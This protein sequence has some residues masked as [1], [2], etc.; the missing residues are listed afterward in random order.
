MDQN[1]VLK[2]IEK[3]VRDVLDSETVTLTMDSNSESV[4]GWDSLAHITILGLL[5]EQF[6][7]KYSLLEMAGFSSVGKIV[8]ATLAKKK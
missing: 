6:R 2:E 3:I 7:V 8:E 4:K 5:E 1:E